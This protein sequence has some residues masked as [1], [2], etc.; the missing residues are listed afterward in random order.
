VAPKSLKKDEVEAKNSFKGEGKNFQMIRT[1]LFEIGS[2]KDRKNFLDE[3][4]FHFAI[5]VSILICYFSSLFAGQSEPF[6]LRTGREKE[7]L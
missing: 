6:L 7:V 2:F 5:L 4:F 3:R 1:S